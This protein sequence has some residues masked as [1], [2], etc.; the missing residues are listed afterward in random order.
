M[1]AVP[2]HHDVAESD[3]VVEGDLA[4]E[5]VLGGQQVLGAAPAVVRQRLSHAQRCRQAKKNTTV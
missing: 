4:D 2:A 1:K 5:V 3:V